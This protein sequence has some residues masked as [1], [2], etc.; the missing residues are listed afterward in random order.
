MLRK[1]LLLGASLFV[2]IGKGDTVRPAPFPLPAYADTEMSTNC[3]LAAWTDRSDKFEVALS[4]DATPSNNVQVA[5]GR[6]H[7][8]DGVLALDETEIIL[9]WDCGQ[10][11]VRFF[12]PEWREFTEDAGGGRREFRLTAELDRSGA[13]RTVVLRD[14]EDAILQTIPA[15]LR[16]ALYSKEW[17]LAR[18]TVRGVD[19]PHESLMVKLTGK[20]MMFLVR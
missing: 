4:F 17:S 18:F 8:Q 13:L 20:G 5:F 9:G 10:W 2:C 3:T 6:D 16:N 15:D 1:L 11:F 7:D 19:R 14:G 12:S